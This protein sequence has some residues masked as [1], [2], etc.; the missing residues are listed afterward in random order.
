MHAD[1]KRNKNHVGFYD[2]GDFAAMKVYYGI[3]GVTP[4]GILVYFRVDDEFKK[5]T[6]W[7]DLKDRWQWDTEQ[8]DRLKFWL[9]ER[10][11]IAAES[12]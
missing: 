8:F 3:D 10:Q 4:V 6:E 1:P 7:R 9:N 2:V 11:K 5:L 12:P